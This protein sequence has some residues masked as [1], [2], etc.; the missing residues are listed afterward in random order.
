MENSGLTL[1]ELVTSMVIVGILVL[2]SI[3]VY[4]HQVNRARISEGI[5]LVS[6]VTRAQ[7]EYALKY[8]TIT[9]D[10]ED[11]NI[12]TDGNKFFKDFSFQTPLS[13]A[14]HKTVIIETE[15]SGDAEGL[16]VERTITIHLISK[17]L[18]LNEIEYST[19]N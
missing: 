10:P 13:A 16:K 2:L 14:T 19:D 11:L 18:T 6:S 1:G 7:Q 9:S 4:R 15:G 8:G 5:S 12:N 17:E 3:P